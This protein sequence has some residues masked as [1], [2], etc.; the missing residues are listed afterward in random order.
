[1]AE[2]EVEG[3]AFVPLHRFLAEPWSALTGGRR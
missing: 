3:I 2:G 1:L